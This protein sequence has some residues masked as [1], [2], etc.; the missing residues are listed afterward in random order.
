MLSV[1]RLVQA[2]T[3]DRLGEDEMKMWADAAVKIVNK[4]FPFDSDD[5]RTWPTCSLLLAHALSSAKRAKN[6]VE[7][8]Q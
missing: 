4:A 3:L 7:R 5:V 1:H 6:E 8:K 2:V